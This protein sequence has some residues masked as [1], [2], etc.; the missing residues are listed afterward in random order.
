VKKVIVMMEHCA[1]DGTPKILE[2]CDLPITG[3][4]VVDLLVTN[5]GVFSIHKDQ[6]LTLVELA[7]DVTLE[8]VRKKTG[9]P[10]RVA[11]DLGK[12]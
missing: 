10:F 4:N 9:C 12:G 5:L 11:D 1:K 8:E 3:K 7:P 6:G 2:E